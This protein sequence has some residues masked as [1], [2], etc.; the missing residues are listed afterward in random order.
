[1]PGPVIITRAEP[2]AGQTAERL[3]AKGLPVIV[4]P[5]LALA[6]T[7]AVCPDLA[8]VAGL[9]FTSAN[10]VRY[11]AMESDRRDLAAWCVGPATAEAAETEGFGTVK[12]ANGDGQALTEAIITGTQPA[13]GPLVHVANAAAKGDVAKGLRAAG[14]EIVFSPLYEACPVATLSPLVNAALS[15]ALSCLILIHSA[16]G[17]SA[18]AAAIGGRDVGQHIAV[19]VSAQAVAPLR[20]RGLARIEVASAPN[21]AALL[22]AAFIAYSTL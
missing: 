3:R 4:S 15:D 18:F 12:N 20:G 2:G 19:G 8:D 22:D 10:G 21:E 14:F 17:A 6:R 1:L 9:I 13:A 11:F 5:M 16:K 7:E